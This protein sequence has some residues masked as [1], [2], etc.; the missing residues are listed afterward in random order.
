M[1]SSPLMHLDM[2]QCFNNGD[3][4]RRYAY[5]ALGS[6]HIQIGLLC[7]L[8][9][10]Q[11][12]CLSL[13]RIL[14]ILTIHHTQRLPTLQPVS[15]NREYRH[16][17]HLGR[18]IPA[19]LPNYAPFIKIP[20]LELSMQKNQNKNIDVRYRR[21]FLSLPF[22]KTDMQDRLPVRL[23]IDVTTKLE[24]TV[25]RRIIWFSVDRTLYFGL[26]FQLSSAKLPSI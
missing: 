11:C 14:C 12:L 7:S 17:S 25:E 6:G 9:L 15:P 26:R 16:G 20:S 23:N 13:R 22:A 21:H 4:L 18:E 1:M 10:Q 8:S 2:W 3:L 24:F 5:S 19:F